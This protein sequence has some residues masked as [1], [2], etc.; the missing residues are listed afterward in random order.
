[1][2]FSPYTRLAIFIKAGHTLERSEAASE[3]A[4]GA[5]HFNPSLLPQD[6]MSLPLLLSGRGPLIFSVAAAL[7]SVETL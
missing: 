7:A 2:H 1:V 6:S 4:E 5:Q 3:A